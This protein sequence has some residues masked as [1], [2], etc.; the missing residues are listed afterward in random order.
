VEAFRAEGISIPFPQRE[1][2]LVGGATGEE[3]LAE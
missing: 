1:V 3:D 2:R